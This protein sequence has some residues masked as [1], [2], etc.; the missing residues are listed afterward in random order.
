MKRTPPPANN[1]KRRQPAKDASKRK[2]ASRLTVLI[3]A[4]LMAVLSI[5]ILRMNGQIR[6]AQAEEAIV[7]QR[8]AELQEANQ[9]LQDDLDN[10]TDPT[11]IE[12]IARDQLGMVCEGEKVFHIS[13]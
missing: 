6:A 7:A 8:L 12:N 9:Q 3:L 4:V 13:K 1:R 10:S 11:L 5:Q 2:P